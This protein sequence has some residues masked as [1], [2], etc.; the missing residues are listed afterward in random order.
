MKRAT[1]LTLV[2]L[3][4]ALLLCGAACKISYDGPSW[5][6]IKDKVRSI[7]LGTVFGYERV[8]ENGVWYWRRTTGEGE[9]A[10]TESPSGWIDALADLTL[11]DLASETK[12]TE[13]IKNTPLSTALDMT[14]RDGVWYTDAACTEKA[15]PILAALADTEIGR[16]SGTVPTLQL[17]YVFGFAPVYASEEDK[18]VIGWTENGQP[19]TD[20]LRAA[21]ADLTIA[22]LEDDQALTDACRHVKTGE[23]LGYTVDENGI[24]YEDAAM[25]KKASPLMQIMC[26]SAVEDLS[27]T[28]DA[29]PIGSLLGYTEGADGVWYTD[30]ENAGNTVPVS[31]I[32]ALIGP[33]TP[34]SG[35]DERVETVKNTETIGAYIDAGLIE[36][37][38]PEQTLAL[39]TVY[40]DFPIDGKPAD[41]YTATDLTLSEFVSWTVSFVVRYYAEHYTGA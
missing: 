17:G 35:L 12:L 7:Q 24:W 9:D 41:A 5:Q 21:L 30:D 19:V 40:A 14:L 26:P 1:A 4:L 13:K 32:F 31:G 22:D 3:L 10:K 25:T 6:E 33:S 20:S 27:R 37:F 18:T 39:Q 36:P 11:G 8:C 29:S 23:V 38:T 34:L 2:I 16:V 28:V 15:T